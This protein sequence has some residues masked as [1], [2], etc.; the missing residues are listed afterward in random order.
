MSEEQSLSLKQKIKDNSAVWHILRTLRGAYEAMVVQK[1]GHRSLDLSQV[2]WTRDAI[3]NDYG[4]MESRLNEYRNRLRVLADMTQ[5]LGAKPI[6]VSQPSRKYRPTPDGIVGD[7]TIGFYDGHE[8]NGVDYYHMMRKLDGVTK[9]VASEK[10]AL[11]VDLSSQPVWLDTDF[12]D[13]L[14]MTPSGAE[15]VGVL[16]SRALRNVILGAEQD[17]ALDGDSAALHPHP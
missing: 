10:D 1:I 4:F 13:F 11:F 2:H 6:F 15:K 16:L 17:T 12:Y 5:G 8:F 3:Q 14:H 7:S 9:A